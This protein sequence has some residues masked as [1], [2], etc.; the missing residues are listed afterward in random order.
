MGLV[1][2]VS[3]KIHKTKNGAYT[4]YFEVHFRYH[5]PITHTLRLSV[6]QEPTKR[7]VKFLDAYC[8]K[9]NICLA[10]NFLKD[11]ITAYF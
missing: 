8:G 10:F 1:S 7:P 4:P 3:E 9:I 2:T 5:T 6:E 11:I